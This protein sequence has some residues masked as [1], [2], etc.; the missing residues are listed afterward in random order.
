MPSTTRQQFERWKLD[1]LLLA[2]PGLSLRPVVN[3]E[4]R[5]AGTLSFNAMA[6]GLERIDD[7]YDVEIIVPRGFPR[8]L[9]L[10]KETDGRIPEDFH[11]NDDGSL[12]LGSPVRQHLALAKSP[13]LMGFVKSCIIP[14]L[15]GYSYLKKHG[16]LPFGELD[17]G[18]K[19]IRNDFAELF[20][21]K[22]RKVAEQLVCLAGRKKRDANKRPCPCG[23]GR[24]LGKCHNRSVNRFR[25][26]LGRTWFREQ[27][28]WLTGK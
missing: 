12:C 3:G 27:Y 1:E 7:S 25:K 4:V 11:T 23:S 26:Q 28:R 14:F 6:A 8:E 13:T 17:H 20:G 2:F 22:D 10:V 5:L 16:S 21:V 24:R 19:G 18:M 15:Y 9:P